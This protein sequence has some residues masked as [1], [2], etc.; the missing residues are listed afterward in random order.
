MG[1]HAKPRSFKKAV[2]IGTGVVGA[3]VPLSI[4]TAPSAQ[5]APISSWDRISQCEA[6][7]LWNRPDGDGGASSGGLQF[8]PASWNYALQ[9]LRSKGVNTSAFPQ[10]PGHQAYKASKRQQILAGEALLAVQGPRAWAVT[11]DGRDGRCSGRGLLTSYGP[12]SSMFRGGVN[13]YAGVPATPAPK[14]RPSTPPPATPTPH[15]K[16]YT[17]QP[18]DNLYVIAKAN[19]FGSGD[20]NWKPLYEANKK[21]IGSNPNLI[22]PGQKLVIPSK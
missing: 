3:A 12:N 5:A 10:G 1:K 8:Q 21:V 16:V 2:V 11:F 20:L 17:V 14:P 22:H 18:G 19:G 4:V 6:A 15:G 13:P 9:V 7:G